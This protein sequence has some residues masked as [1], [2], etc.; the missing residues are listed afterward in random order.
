M[1]RIVLRTGL[2]LLLALSAGLFITGR[3]ESAMKSTVLA[4][5]RPPI[6]RALPARLETATFALG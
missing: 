1:N 2:G 4:A 6:D 3:G 5:D